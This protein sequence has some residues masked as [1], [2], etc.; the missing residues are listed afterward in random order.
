[1][2]TTPNSIIAPRPNII[3]SKKCVNPPT[4]H[5]DHSDQLD[6]RQILDL[7]TAPV[8]P[9]RIGQHLG[10]VFRQQRKAHAVRK[11]LMKNHNRIQVVNHKFDF[12]LIPSI[13]LLEI[14]ETFKGMRVSI[15]V[16]LDTWTGY[17]LYFNW[18]KERSENGLVNALEPFRDQLDNILL[19][20]TDGATYFPEVVR[21]LCP[22]AVHQ[23]CL[24]HVIRNLFRP[25]RAGRIPYSNA[26]KK[27]KIIRRKIGR[28]KQT[29]IKRRKRVKNLRQ[30]VKYWEKSRFNLRLRLGVK[31]SQKNIL[32]KYPR[33]KSLNDGLNLRRTKVRSM[34]NSAQNVKAR[35][36]VLKAELKQAENTM[37]VL[38]AEYMADWRLFHRFYD[39]FDLKPK[40]YAIQRIE[41]IK[42]LQNTGSELGIEILRV[43]TTIKNLDSVK[44]P[45]SP[46]Q[47]TK[48]LINTNFIEST[49]SRIRPYLE[50][51]RK[52]G[53]TE[54]CS[55]YFDLIRLYLNTCRVFSGF[56]KGTS[57][58]ERLGYDM[59][60]RN[61]LDVIFDG[62]PPGPQNGINP[63]KLNVNVVSPERASGCVINRKEGK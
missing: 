50:I 1:M 4:S 61:Y 24:V 57:P 8:S 7:L 29:T 60:H 21:N 9:N 38:W 56:R 22:Q 49:N 52:I 25:M 32:M 15:L 36:L 28:L 54:Y 33:L 3:F 11:V 42:T 18:L 58:V 55:A 12:I 46:I 41:L 2:H 27:V 17:I 48:S 13:R 30:Q 63:A 43:L 5:P 6:E 26:K 47:M 31:A 59:R 44:Q 23:I 14:D 35:N 53:D 16:V 34:N 20:L 10:N 19:V 39:L 51:L 62:F 37:H 45:D 40:N